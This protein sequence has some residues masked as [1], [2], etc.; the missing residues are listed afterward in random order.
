MDDREIPCT[1][2]EVSTTTRTCVVKVG[3]LNEGYL[4]TIS[5]PGVTSTQGKPLL[6]DRIYYTL[7]KK[8]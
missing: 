4:Y 3:E 5:L 1:V 2:T 6:G 7:Q 8:R